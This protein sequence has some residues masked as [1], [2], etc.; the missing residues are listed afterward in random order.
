[1]DYHQCGFIK[2]LEIHTHK[3]REIY[4]RPHDIMQ[5]IE[6][7]D[8]PGT[9]TYWS[10]RLKSEKNLIDIDEAPHEIFSQIGEIEPSLR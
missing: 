4:V 7:H 9:A 10:I 2:L 6:M 3:P 8:T 5:I 1:M